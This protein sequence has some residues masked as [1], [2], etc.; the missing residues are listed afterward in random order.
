MDLT[1]LERFSVWRIGTSSEETPPAAAI[2]LTVFRYLRDSEAEKESGAARFRL[3][4]PDSPRGCVDDILH[5][6]PP[7]IMF[8]V[9]EKTE[10][11]RCRLVLATWIQ[12][13]I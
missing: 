3:G 2:A 12:I 7:T 11:A 4:R 9:T 8:L 13:L 6:H 5:I 1:L 10:V